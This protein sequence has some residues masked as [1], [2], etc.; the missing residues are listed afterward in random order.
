MERGRYTARHEV[1]DGVRY[2]KSKNKK[3]DQQLALSVVLDLVPIFQNKR[4]LK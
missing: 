4:N 2:Q 1:A 3:I